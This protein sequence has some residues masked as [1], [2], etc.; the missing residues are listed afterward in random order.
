M[1]LLGGLCDGAFVGGIMWR[2]FCGGDCVEGFV[3]GIM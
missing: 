3:G 2:S 1:F